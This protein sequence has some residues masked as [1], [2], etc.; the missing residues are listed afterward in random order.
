MCIG[1]EQ[2][3]F[4][5]VNVNVRRKKKKELFWPKSNPHAGV[6]RLFQF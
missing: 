2:N 4:F 3:Q 5:W 1:L 6:R